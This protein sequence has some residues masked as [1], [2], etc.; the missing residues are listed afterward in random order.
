MGF[1]SGLLGTT[2]ERLQIDFR[3]FSGLFWPGFDPKTDS[4]IDKSILLPVCGSKRGSKEPKKRL[5]LILKMLSSSQLIIREISS[6]ISPWIPFLQI[7]K[8]PH[9]IKKYQ[10]IL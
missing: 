9:F 1:F 3:R 10:T 5:K 4:N 6:S 2:I 8:I 7:T